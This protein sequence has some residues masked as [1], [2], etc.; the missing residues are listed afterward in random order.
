MKVNELRIGN[1]INGGE[2]IQSLPMHEGVF[3]AILLANEFQSFGHIVKISNLK[4]IPLTEE[5]LIKFG[6]NKT[7]ETSPYSYY[8]GS[9]KRK[10]WKY[11]RLQ[12]ATMVNTE[13]LKESSGYSAVY[14]MNKFWS[15]CTHVH[16][17]Q[18]LYFALTD[19]ELEIK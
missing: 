10:A 11:V 3:C 19:K 2:I 6:F 5:W 13:S 4:P 18:N 16:Q 17:L 7:K 15:A 1:F 12:Y 8:L 9:E 14:L